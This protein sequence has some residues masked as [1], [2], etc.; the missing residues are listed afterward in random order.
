MPYP[1]KWHELTE[2][3]LQP[4]PGFRT[5]RPGD[6]RV[7]QFTANDQ[8]FLAVHSLQAYPEPIATEFRF[9]E[10]ER[11][12]D[13]T[14]MRVP[15]EV[16]SLE[17]LTR[18]TKSEAINNQALRSVYKRIGHFIGNAAQKDELLVVDASNF[19]YARDTNQLYVVPPVTVQDGKPSVEALGK[20]FAGSLYELLNS[21]L[22]PDAIRA[23][24]AEV[25]RGVY[26]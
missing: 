5:L 7:R 9:E 16:L 19:A 20:T 2:S 25:M 18:G 8:E 24:A 10:V 17:A 3:S 26:E 14:L 15:T 21:T 4:V 11:N 13:Y 23:L 1:K 6:G 22:A 12:D